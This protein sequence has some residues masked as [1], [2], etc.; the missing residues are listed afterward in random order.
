MKRM[1]LTC[2]IIAAIA[3]LASIA[4]V[5]SSQPV[6]HIRH[7]G[8]VGVP[9]VGE[10][11]FELIGRSDQN[12][13]NATHYGYLTHIAGLADDLLFSHPVTR[14][15]ATARFTYFATTTIDARHQVGNIISTAAPGTLT[16]FFSQTAGAD[17]SNPASFSNDQP[18]ASFSLRYH[19]VLNVQVPFS[20]QTHGQGSAWAVADLSQ[21]S[22]SHFT[23]NGRR[24]MLGHMAVRERLSVTGQG[25]LIQAD[26]PQAVFLL[27]GNVVISDR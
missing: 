2:G 1:F 3:A 22:A 6:S 8:I 11:A 13:L 21:E 27:G 20:P 4:H 18:I 26:P 19:N 5:A 24:F 23:L 9:P 7:S 12:G 14:T 10:N 25:T 17:F 15:E 16:I